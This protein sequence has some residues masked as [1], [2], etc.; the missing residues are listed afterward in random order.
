MDRCIFSNQGVGNVTNCSEFNFHADSEAAFVTLNELQ[1]DVTMATLE[2]CQ[3]QALNWVQ[4]IFV[5]QCMAV[6]SRVDLIQYIN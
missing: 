3:T 4:I 1:C 6:K 5:H 2:F